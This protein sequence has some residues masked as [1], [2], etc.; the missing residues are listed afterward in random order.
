MSYP[1][2]AA[3]KGVPDAVLEEDEAVL[4]DLH[5]VSTVEKHVPLLQHVPDLLPLRLLR[6][7]QVPQEGCLGRDLRQVQSSLPFG[8]K[9]KC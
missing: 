2:C 3:P 1:D 9:E 6:V 5:Q 4:I 7:V 8:W